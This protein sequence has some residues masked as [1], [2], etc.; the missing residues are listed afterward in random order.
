[1][2]GIVVLDKEKHKNYHVKP[3]PDLAHMK[4]QNVCTVS[5]KEMS[6]AVNNF[7]VVFVKHPQQDELRV[8]ALLGFKPGENLYYDPT[9][10]KCNYAPLVMLRTPFVIGPD[11]SD[12]GKRLV[13][14]LDEDSPYLTESNEGQPL[15][16]EDGSESDYLKGQQQLLAEIFDGEVRTIRF[17]KRMQ[18]LDLISEFEVSIQVRSGAINRYTGLQTINEEKIKTLDAS[19]L[20]ELHDKGYLPVIYMMLGSLGQLN[21]LVKLRNLASSEDPIVN[22]QVAPAKKEEAA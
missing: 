1:M 10:W 12:E 9:Q 21:Q 14:C 17:V 20:K 5:V 3:N 19:V 8:V 7:P 13:P 2:A 4:N 11:G 16:K 6:R 18:E 22:M 15:F